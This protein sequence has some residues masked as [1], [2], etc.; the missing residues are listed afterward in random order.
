[1]P[2]LARKN[3][4]DHAT[5][6]NRAGVDVRQP[7]LYSEI[8][9]QVPR[10]EVVQTVHKKAH[11]CCDVFG[12]VGV[13]VSDHGLHFNV[14]IDRQQSLGSGDRLGPRSIRIRLTI[15]HLPL[16]ICLLDDIPINKANRPHTSA[17]EQIHD[18]TPECAASDNQDGCVT[19]FLLARFAKVTQQHL[20]VIP[21]LRL[22]AFDSQFL[23]HHAKCEK[24]LFASA[25]RCVC[26]RTVQ[27]FPSPLAAS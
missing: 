24:A 4:H 21:R 19:K 20:S 22:S 11:A 18:T 16:Q 5:C 14:R 2:T 27:A 23:P 3:R 12:V 25:M 13:K 9:Q 10:I 8:I 7:V 6:S 26:S 15:Q 17:G 1:M